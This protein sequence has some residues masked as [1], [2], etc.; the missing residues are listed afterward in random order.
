MGQAQSKVRRH[1]GRSEPEQLCVYCKAVVWWLCLV[2]ADFTSGQTRSALFFCASWFSQE[3]KRVARQG[4]P[5]G[6]SVLASMYLCNRD[7]CGCIVHGG[8]MSSKSLHWPITCQHYFI[9]QTCGL[10]SN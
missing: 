2:L 9:L 5:V 1:G 10:R 7:M 3:G 8:D 4:S 6:P